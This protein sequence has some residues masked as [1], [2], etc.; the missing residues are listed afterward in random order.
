MN[1]E[2]SENNELM[3]F[4]QS[5]I[6]DE[7]EREILNNVLVKNINEELIDDLLAIL[8]NNDD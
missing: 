1:N 4:F 3:E 5:M 7:T 2:S 8:E 6:T